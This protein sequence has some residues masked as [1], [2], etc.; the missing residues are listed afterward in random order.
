MTQKLAIKGVDDE[1]VGKAQDVVYRTYNDIGPDSGWVD[2]T[3][4][5]AVFVDVMID[6]FRNTNEAAGIMTDAEVDR[7]H[8]LSMAA[9]RKIILSVGP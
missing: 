7:F 2:K 9:K 3:P 5:K 4:S 6:Q 8:A 1:F